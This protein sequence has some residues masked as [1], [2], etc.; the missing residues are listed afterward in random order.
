[1]TDT[2]RITALS[3]IILQMTEIDQNTIDFLAR[4]QNYTKHPNLALVYYHLCS[5]DPNAYVWNDET[6]I[7]EEGKPVCE[8]LLKAIGQPVG[9]QE[10]AL[11]Q[12]SVAARDTSSGEIRACASCNEIIFGTL[13]EIEETT[14]DDLHH[15]FLLT[16]DQ[17]TELKTYSAEMIQDFISV[18]QLP[19][20]ILPSQP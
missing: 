4:S 19:W 15:S 6:L 18:T 10:S 2:E 16:E 17:E 20:P 12:E 14:W 9:Q 5:S 8:R 13:D 7:G 1:M 3:E 11:C